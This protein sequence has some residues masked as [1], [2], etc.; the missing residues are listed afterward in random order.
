MTII[1]AEVDLNLTISTNYSLLKPQ[2]GGEDEK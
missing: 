2:N 1:S